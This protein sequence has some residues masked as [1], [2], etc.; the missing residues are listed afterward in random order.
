MIGWYVATTFLLLGFLGLL[1]LVRRLR[2]TIEHLKVSVEILADNVTAYREATEG[3]V[4]Y[5]KQEL[6]RKG[7][8]HR[9]G[10]FE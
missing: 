2:T 1:V 9:S 8:K 10:G 7:R 6:A 3:V 5:K 4:M